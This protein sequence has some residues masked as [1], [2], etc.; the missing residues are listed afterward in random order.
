MIENFNAMIPSALNILDNSGFTFYPTGSRYFGGASE[1]SDWDFLVEHDGEVCQFLLNNG[2]VHNDSGGYFGDATVSEVFT[3]NRVPLSGKPLIKIDI[4]V[5]HQ[6]HLSTKL[7]I[8][9]ILKEKYGNNGLPGD[10]QVRKEIW[11]LMF[12]A[13]QKLNIA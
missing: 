5:V 2:F 3:Y 13:L 7:L 12:F 1:T 10:K 11:H 9:K 4:Q 8:Q 6:E